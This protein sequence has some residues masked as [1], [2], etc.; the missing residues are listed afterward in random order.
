MKSDNSIDKAIPAGSG[1]YDRII[2]YTGV[3]GGVQGLMTLVTMVR[4]KIVAR[5]LGTVGFGISELFNRTLNTV[6]S[7]TDLGIPFSAVRTVSANFDSECDDGLYESVLVTRTW[8]LLTA[9]CGTLLCAL[10]SP[11]LGGHVADNEVNYTV[12]FLLL[13][14]AV[15][16][17]A[18]TGGEMAILKGIRKLRE[19]AV[20]QMI[21]VVLALFISIP[22]FYFL[23]LR[24]LVLSIVLVS[25]VTMLVTCWYSFR[26][27][28]YKIG[29][30]RRNVLRSGFEMVRVGIYFTLASF[31]GSGAFAI[32]A[33]YLLRYGGPEVTGAYSAGYA[34]MNYLGSFV[35]ASMESDYFPRLSSSVRSRNVTYLQANRQIEISILI[36]S[37]MIAAFI[38]FLE[39]VVRLLLT[40]KFC[41]AI[42]M[43]RIA[44]LS[45][46][47][48]AVTQPLAFV[49]LAKGDSKT[50]LLQEVLSDFFFVGSVA[51]C[52]HLGGLTMTGCAIAATGAFDLIVVGAIVKKRYGL[53]L[54][55]KAMSLIVVLAVPVALVFISVTFL[56]GW[57]K[58]IS[59][60][61][62]F[63][64]SLGVSY[65]ELQ[66]RTTF[67]DILKS[68]INHRLGL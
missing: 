49:S 21:T 29:L 10:L 61:L 4:T 42:P 60:V 28:P 2:K 16:F 3:F 9:V 45:L 52:F 24:G 41:T 12:S 20:S 62:L 43:A 51:F 8:S 40:A 38:V 11:L 7:T 14:P 48:K 56:S 65:F 46:F 37:P 50:Y 44:V 54:S 68:K 53:R 1:I 23:R 47:F 18:I 33:N 57:V 35:L 13:S 27:I 6:K 55:Y 64:L 34:L 26:A 67:I 22:V 25:F 32:V 5:L 66:R 17:S 36:M 59:G 30:S 58:W 15:A 63:A 19:I 39:P 31:F